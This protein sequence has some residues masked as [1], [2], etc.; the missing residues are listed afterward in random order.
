MNDIVEINLG[1][2]STCPR[3]WQNYI[4][5]NRIDGIT[6]DQITENIRNLGIEYITWDIQLQYAT[7][8]FPAAVYTWFLLRWT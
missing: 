6:Y 3:W 4:A 1:M 7:L 8:K 5:E 2:L